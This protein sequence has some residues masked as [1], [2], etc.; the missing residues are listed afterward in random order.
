MG[1]SHP[2][3][4]TGRHTILSR[5]VH[6]NRRTDLRSVSVKRNVLSW[7]RNSSKD[8]AALIPIGML[9]HKLGAATAKALSA[10]LVLVGC[11]VNCMRCDDRRFRTGRCSLRISFRYSGDS[12]ELRTLY[13]SVR[14]LNMIRCWIGSQ[15]SCRRNWSDMFKLSCAGL[16]PQN[17]AT[18]EF[19]TPMKLLAQYFYW[20]VI[21]R[22]G[23]GGLLHRLACKLSLVLG[24]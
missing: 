16:Q 7:E 19:C 1:Q 20:V 21:S 5:P 2:S 6:L 3:Q 11:V 14:I 12:L 18:T 15:W 17:I 10:I 8:S 24:L 9:F 23:R 13:V 22:I 4:L